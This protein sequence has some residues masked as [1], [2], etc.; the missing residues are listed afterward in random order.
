M[1]ISRRPTDSMPNLG[2]SNGENIES[3]LLYENTWEDDKEKHAMLANFEVKEFERVKA[4]KVA[5]LEKK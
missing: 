2:E 3:R 1:T 5:E 4:G